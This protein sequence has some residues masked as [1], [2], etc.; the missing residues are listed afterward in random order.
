MN[1][2]LGQQINIESFQFSGFGTTCQKINVFID[3][4]IILLVLIHYTNK[5]SNNKLG[6][7]H[8]LFIARF[9]FK[10]RVEFGQTI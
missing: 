3:L 5:L 7:Y 10:T 4:L 9:I 2:V 8:V 1:Y 6:R